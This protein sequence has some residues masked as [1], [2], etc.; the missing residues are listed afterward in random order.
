MRTLA[1]KTK[2]GLSTNAS[3]SRSISA[4]KITDACYILSAHP[5][6][7]CRASP[8]FALMASLCRIELAFPTTTREVV[9]LTATSTLPI[10]NANATQAMKWCRTNANPL[11]AAL[12]TPSTTP[13]SISVTV[14]KATG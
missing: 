14:L 9:G 13:G 5:T 4:M 1:V 8:A 10:K 7:T 11:L 12:P 2:Y 6:A 3:A